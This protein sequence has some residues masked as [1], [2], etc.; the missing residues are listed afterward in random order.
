M[1]SLIG[2]IGSSTSHGAG[3]SALSLGKNDNK[4]AGSEQVA[5]MGTSI[6]SNI[7]GHSSQG[8][9]S[10]QTAFNA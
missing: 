5:Y 3:K 6:F 2:A 4:K 1:S 7:G 10:T 8:T 9:Q